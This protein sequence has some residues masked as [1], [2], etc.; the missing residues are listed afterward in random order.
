M[1]S[2]A[3]ATIPRAMFALQAVFGRFFESNIE[4]G[5]RIEEFEEMEMIEWETSPLEMEM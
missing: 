3:S 2:M 5:A 1:I 4:I